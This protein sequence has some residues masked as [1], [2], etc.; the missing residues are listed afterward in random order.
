VAVVGG[1]PAGSTVAHRLAAAGVQVA[2][3]ERATFPRDKACG[4]GVSGDGLAALVRSGL[5]EWAS[6]FAAPEVLRLTAPDGQPL[7]V[8]PDTDPSHCYGRTI[9]RRLLDAR[10]AQAAVDAGARLLE[11]TRVQHVERSNGGP[12]RV[13]AGSL[14]VEAELAI[15]ADGSNAGVTRR[16]GL[17][18][19]EPELL[20]IRQYFAGDT[21]PA[22]RLEIH[23]ERW[24]TPGYTWVFPMNNGHIN[25][26]TGTFT[27]R[28]RQGGVALR[29][30]LSRFTSDQAAA[31]GR[32][33]QAEPAGP[34]RGHALRT[35]LGDTRTHAERMLVV[36]DAA[37]LV[38]P[39]SGEGIARAL[40][41]G[42]LA[43]AHALDALETGD[44]TAQALSRYSRELV[45]RYRA[46]QRAA[47]ILR[48]ALNAP[49]LL[50]RVF[51]RL[52]QDK[53]LALLIGHIIIGD[54]SPRLAL[55]PATLLR[56][57]T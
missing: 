46:D 13:V 41:S 39:L 34:V 8:R 29:E 3:L 12:I 44:L 40:E 7:D 9:P 6:Q 27:W 17:V 33:S 19:R 47:R 57:L 20:A 21:G 56:L 2:L 35:R 31:G 26:G 16:L 32:L 4:D 23:F 24:I 11:S 48:L 5:G 53:G 28:V 14:A 25:V 51:D 45:S 37:G 15:L 54:K 30:V 38:D 43:A 55:R 10:L 22:E 36:G 49:R 18:K 50:N 52:R 42:E 1:G